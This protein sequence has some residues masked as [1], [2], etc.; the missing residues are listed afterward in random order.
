MLINLLRN[1]MKGVLVPKTK[2]RWTEAKENK[3]SYDWKVRNILIS[4][5]GLINIISFPTYD[6]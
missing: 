6:S 4:S 2:A 1:I 3:F 5:M